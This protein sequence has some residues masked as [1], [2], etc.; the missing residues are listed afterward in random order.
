M[1]CSFISRMERSWLDERRL[2]CVA[3]ARMSELVKVSRRRPSRRPDTR[4]E[5]APESVA[6]ASSVRAAE[7]ENVIRD[8]IGRLDRAERAEFET[9]GHQA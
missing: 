4:I 2:R 7:F 5:K 6:E 9:P 8:A 1:N 3:K